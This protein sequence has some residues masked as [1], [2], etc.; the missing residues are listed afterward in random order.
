MSFPNVTDMLTTTIEARGKVLRD[1]VSNSNPMLMKMEAKGNTRTFSGGHTIRE[2]FMFAENPNAGWFNGYD[3]L[4]VGAADVISAAEFDPKQLACAV[5]IS[6]REKLLNS[7]P[8]G[9]IDLMKGRV[10]AAEKTMR[11]RVDYGL[12]SD[13]TAFGGKILTGLS[14][15]VPTD[16]TTGTYGGIDRSNAAW[17]FWRSQVKTHT[18]ATATI[19]ADM[20]DLYVACSRGTDHP[21]LILAGGTSFKFFM[22]SLQAIQ[23]IS[24]P[25]LAEAGFTTVRFM[26]AD[27]VLDGGIGGNM[28]AT[29]M[30]FLNTDYIH[31][32]PHADCNF[33]PMGGSG[34][35]RR[36]AVN[37]DADVVLISF[38]GNLTM[39]GAQFQGRYVGA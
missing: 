7:G 4:A 5:T 30:V 37:Q 15:A 25:K 22:T 33:V 16:P 32:R 20:T 2:E 19:Q 38:M 9:L 26:G 28:L 18:A 21:D 23:R 29:D 3:T 17:A 31:W 24:D 1:N 34:N 13:G 12:H 10:K 27:V 8:Q 11:N 6:G 14:A 35:N 39:S 36:Q